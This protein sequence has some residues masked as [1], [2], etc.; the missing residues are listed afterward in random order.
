MVFLTEKSS[1]QFTELL[2][3]RV[4][5]HGLWC[6]RNKVYTTFKL[7]FEKKKNHLPG[8]CVNLRINYS[9][10]PAIPISYNSILDCWYLILFPSPLARI[11]WF[12][13]YAINMS[14]S[15]N[16][17]IICSFTIIMVSLI[18]LSPGLPRHLLQCYVSWLHDQNWLLIRDHLSS[19]YSSPS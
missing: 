10:P 9:K 1:P 17:V 16:H 12:A 15:M 14:F 18:S 4:A 11:Y 6:Y 5:V 19:L 3:I 8:N 13:F 2:I 7:L